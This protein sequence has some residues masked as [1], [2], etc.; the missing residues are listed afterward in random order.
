MQA[1]IDPRDFGITAEDLRYAA[2][3]VAA[4]GLQIAGW[5]SRHAQLPDLLR[6]LAEALSLLETADRREYRYL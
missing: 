3:A 2:I 4:T 5:E 6:E 1:I